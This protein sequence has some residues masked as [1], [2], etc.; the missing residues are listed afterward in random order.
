MPDLTGRVRR[1]GVLPAAALRAASTMPDPRGRVRP[2]RRRSLRTGAA[3]F[4]DA[5]P[6]RPG[7]PW[8]P[9]CLDP[10]RNC[11]NDARPGAGCTRGMDIILITQQPLQQCPTGPVGCA[12][13]S[14]TFKRGAPG[15]NDARPSAVGRALTTATR[16]SLSSSCFNEARSCRPGAVTVLERRHLGLRA[17]TMPDRDDRVQHH[18]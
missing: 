2:Q 12:R 5:R 13:E 1:V 6:G 15:L 4:N 14:N 17:S 9:P 11:F 16:A 18:E 3:C 10:G 7:T 8:P